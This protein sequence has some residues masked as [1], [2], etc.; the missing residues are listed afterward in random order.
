MSRRHQQSRRR[1]YGRRQHELHER[2]ERR[3]PVLSENLELPGMLDLDT[4][5]N[6]LSRLAFGGRIVSWAEGVA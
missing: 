1:S 6:R 2:R 3:D 5:A 4:A